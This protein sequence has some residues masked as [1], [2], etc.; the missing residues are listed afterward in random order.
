MTKY[1]N[2]LPAID[3]INEMTNKELNDFLTSGICYIKKELVANTEKSLHLVKEK[4]NQFFSQTQTEKSNYKEYNDRRTIELKEHVERLSFPTTNPPVYFKNESESLLSAR[5]ELQQNIVNPLILK[6]F[7]YFDKTEM[8]DNFIESEGT[9]FSI[10]SYPECEDNKEG[11]V[12]GLRK[13]KDF[14]ILT[15][16]SLNESGLKRKLNNN[17]DDWL[18]VQPDPNYYVVVIGKALQLILGKDKCYAP[19]HKVDLKDEK[20]L[21]MGIFFNPQSSLPITNVFTSEQLFEN[22]FP[23]YIS[24][25]ISNYKY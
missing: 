16:L 23:S 1:I 17:N 3:N 24:Q 7:K 5:N 12:T 21:S 10:V 2:G 6:I 9:Y 13:H 15:L 18:E 11:S 22:F 8:S 20:R 19:S 25:M 14:G 4:A